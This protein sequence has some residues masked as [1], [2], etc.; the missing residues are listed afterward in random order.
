MCCSW[1]TTMVGRK[2]N[3]KILTSELRQKG[4]RTLRT[5]EFVQGRTCR[6]GLA[7]SYNSPKEG[8]YSQRSTPTNNN[9]SSFMIEVN[10]TFPNAITLR[11]YISFSRLELNVIFLFPMLIFSFEKWFWVELEGHFGCAGAAKSVGG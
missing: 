5:T 1:F 8:L 11:N 4:V 2:V 7:W 3:L 9:R 10:A 6:W